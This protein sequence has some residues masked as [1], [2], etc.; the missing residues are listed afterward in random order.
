M[1]LEKIV[2]GGVIV[3]DTGPAGD[4]NGG[5]FA[6]W[7]TVASLGTGRRYLAA[8][9]DNNGLLYAI[10]GESSA[11][12]HES[13]VEQYD[14]STDT[15]TTVAS[16][17]TGRQYLAATVDNNGLLYAIG[18]RSS[19]T[20]YESVVEQ[21]DFNPSYA[22]AYSA[23]G[24]TLFAV[25]DPNAELKNESTGRVVTGDSLIA[26]NGETIAWFSEEQARLFRTEET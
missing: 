19:A 20:S 3:E 24:D 11:N 4:P 22:T 25:D 17:G 23:T 9:V 26:R 13:V 1:S 12:T 15:W 5:D 2:G 8:T 16:L 18:G 10:G 14:P 6:G 21:S 7:T